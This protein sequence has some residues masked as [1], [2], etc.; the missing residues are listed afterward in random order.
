MPGAR[1]KLELSVP[2]VALQIAAA[3]VLPRDVEGVPVGGH[4]MNVLFF[5]LDCKFDI[6]RL[7]TV[8][9]ARVQEALTAPTVAAG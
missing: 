1:Q 6:F 9:Q 5:D 4:G 2:I 8:M 7:A 3:C